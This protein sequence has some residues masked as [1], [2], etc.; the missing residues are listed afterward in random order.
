MKAKDYKVE[1]ICT[2]ESIVAWLL[3]E[4]DEPYAPPKD[5]NDTG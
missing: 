1:G 3:G 5:D 4:Q 2:M